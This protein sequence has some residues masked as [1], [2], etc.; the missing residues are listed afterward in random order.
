[1]SPGRTA[2]RENEGA[3][4]TVEAAFS[5]GKP[6]AATLPKNRLKARIETVVEKVVISAPSSNSH[7]ADII[8]R[9]RGRVVKK[10]LRFCQLDGRAGCDSY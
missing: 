6:P 4:G 3:H 1:V 10:M 8:F 9:R 2:A 7:F 5:T